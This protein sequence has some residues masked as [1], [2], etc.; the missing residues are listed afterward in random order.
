M[1]FE[2]KGNMELVEQR[3]AMEKNLISTVRD[4]ERLKAQLANIPQGTELSCY[5]V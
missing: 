2:K 4:V 5:V 1:E 3:A